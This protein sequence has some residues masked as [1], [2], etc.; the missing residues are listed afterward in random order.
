MIVLLMG[1][2]GVGKGTYAKKLEEKYNIP[3]ISTGDIFREN[4]KN[5]TA[6]GKIAK[7]YI[8]NGNLVP[9]KITIN[10]LKKRIEQEDCENGF[11]LDGFPR[12]IAQAEALDADLTVDKVLF[13]TAND[14]TIIERL[15]GRRVCKKCGANYH[16]KFIPPKKEGICDACGGELY[17][18]EDDHKEA[19]EKRLDLFK[20]QTLPV[21]DYYKNKKLVAIIDSLPI[22]R[23][24]EV[25]N[26]VEKALRTT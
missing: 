18:R 19:I 25:M 12:T 11:F 15:E 3:T 24:A 10:M 8:D 13:F 23:V 22:K 14:K 26:N 20:K 4:I 5:Q 21:I 6:T 7:S 16:V 1:P 17:Q 2:Q 9:D